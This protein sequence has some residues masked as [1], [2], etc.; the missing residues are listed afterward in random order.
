MD[1]P[2]VVFSRSEG[3]LNH[4]GATYGIYFDYGDSELLSSGWLSG[5]GGHQLFHTYEDAKKYDELNA[6]NLLYGSNVAK[7]EALPPNW[8]SVLPKWCMVTPVGQD[9]SAIREFFEVR[10]VGGKR[11][12]VLL[13]TVRSNAAP[14]VKKKREGKKLSRKQKKR[15]KK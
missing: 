4:E 14:K 2:T 15:L 7:I 6:N 10:K 9:D 12:P 11:T 5:Q 8:K 3:I 13:R 1:S